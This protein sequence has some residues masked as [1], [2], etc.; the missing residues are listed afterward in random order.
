M[1]QNIL[2][3]VIDT[4]DKIKRY[5]Y[6]LLWNDGKGKQKKTYKNVKKMNN[7]SSTNETAIDIQSTNC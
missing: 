1:T 4:N 2:N 5:V 6:L 3:T 7:S